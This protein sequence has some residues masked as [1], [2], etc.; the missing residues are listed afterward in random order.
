V[1]AA[2]IG[3]A[4]G[5]RY[6][7]AGNLPGGVGPWENTVCPSCKTLLIERRG[8]EILANRLQEGSCPNC[9]QKIPGFWSSPVHV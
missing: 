6:V 9:R 1:E 8:F 7:Y 4:A 2:E 5:L 3:A